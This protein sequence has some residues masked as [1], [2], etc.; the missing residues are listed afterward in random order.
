MSFDLD[1]FRLRALRLIE[2]LDS[3]HE[4][5]VGEE[6][7]YV[8]EEILALARALRGNACNTCG[9]RGSRAYGSTA[10]WRGGVGGQSITSGI[11]D[12][13]W[14]TGRNDRTGVNLKKFSGMMRKVQ[15]DPC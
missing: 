8:G 7:E 13:C 5:F 6:S 2:S 15:K 4:G 12:K 9:G 14:G 1:E 11:C 3:A 10:T